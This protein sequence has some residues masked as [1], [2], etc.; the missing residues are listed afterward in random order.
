MRRDQPNPSAPMG[1]RDAP[2]RNNDPGVLVLLA[3]CLTLARCDRP[4]QPY[5]DLALAPQ[6]SDDKQSAV[7]EPAQQVDAHE[8]AALT[9]LAP[10]AYPESA[11]QGVVEILITGCRAVEEVA[12]PS[13][14]RYAS[15]LTYK[16]SASTSDLARYFYFRLAET[17][18]QDQARFIALTR[19]DGSSIQLCDEPPTVPNR[20]GS[21]SVVRWTSVGA[22]T[23]K[24]KQLP[25][26]VW[27]ATGDLLGVWTCMSPEGT[28]TILLNADSLWTISDSERPAGWARYH[29][30]PTAGDFVPRRGLTC[31]PV[32]LTMPKPVPRPP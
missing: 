18:G 20:H 29:Y 7:P 32:T 22:L 21:G 5:P 14:P 19:E 27:E 17:I 12:S 6:D 3:L 26:G 31:P 10:A 30:T 8:P 11:R 24:L 13:A 1:R 2:S 15:W 9:P 4:Q 28:A 23:L 25:S 16:I